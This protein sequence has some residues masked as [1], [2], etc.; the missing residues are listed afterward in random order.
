MS[1]NKHFDQMDLTCQLLQKQSAGSKSTPFKNRRLRAHLC[2]PLRRNAW[3]RTAGSESHVHIQVKVS[4]CTNVSN[5]RLFSQGQIL[6]P[7]LKTTES[8][9][10]VTAALHPEHAV[11]S[12]PR[13]G[14]VSVCKHRALK[15]VGPITHLTHLTVPI[16]ASAYYGNRQDYQND[17][18]TSSGRIS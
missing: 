16:T 4:A 12:P 5:L 2:N 1:L 8:L 3:H 7:D 9:Q 15:M 14:C 11:E 17:V 6:T 10:A 13:K 18:T